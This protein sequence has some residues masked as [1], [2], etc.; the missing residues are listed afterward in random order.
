MF[1]AP[2][3]I[4]TSK[5]TPQITQARVSRIKDTTPHGRQDNRP[6][7]VAGARGGSKGTPAGSV[8]RTSHR[9][10]PGSGYLCIFS[11][12][13]RLPDSI[14]SFRFFHVDFQTGFTQQNN[15]TAVRCQPMF[16]FFRSRVQPAF[17]NPISPPPGRT[18]DLR[19]YHA[20]GQQIPM[21]HFFRPLRTGGQSRQNLSGTSPKCAR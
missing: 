3:R 15:G 9:R 12:S 2:L 5:W 21:I 7:R 13:I 20:P 14:Q 4:R 18:G 8:P 17:I 16:G 10:Y 19:L 6:A 11:F 1:V